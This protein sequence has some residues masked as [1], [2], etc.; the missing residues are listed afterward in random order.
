METETLILGSHQ[1]QGETHGADPPSE[2]PEG[3]TL[4]V[5]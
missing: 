2:P 1:K 3:M 4:S 5:P